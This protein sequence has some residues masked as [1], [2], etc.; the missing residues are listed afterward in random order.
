MSRH[1]DVK[2]LRR[3]KEIRERRR[4]AE[5]DDLARWHLRLAA[6]H[7]LEGRLQTAIEESEKALRCREDLATAHQGLAELLA[8]SNPRRALQHLRRFLELRPGTLANWY[9]RARLSFVLDEYSD[10]ESACDRLLSGEFGRLHRDDRKR[11]QEM[12]SLNEHLRTPPEFTP[13]TVATKRT[14]AAAVMQ[15]ERPPAPALAPAP[16]PA[17]AREVAITFEFEDLALR[18]AERLPPASAVDYH[19]RLEALDLR[20]FDH[21]AALLA[22][23]TA[24]GLTHF[25]HQIE[26]VKRVL[27]EF[28]GRA[29]LADEVGLGKTIEAC[30]ILK[31]YLLRGLVRRV[32]ILTPPS[33]VEQWR[34]ELHAKFSLEFV[35][36]EHARFR[37]DRERFLKEQRCVILSLD[38]ARSK[39]TRDLLAAEEYDLIIVDEAH[40]LRR[41]TSESWKL[42]DSLKSRML[43]MLTAT[44]IQNDLMELYNLITLLK[45]GHLKTAKQF[46][47]DYVESGD[48][49]SPR[50]RE[51]L[52]R[53]LGEVMI[54][55]TRAAVDVGLPPRRAET[56]RLDPGP[57]EIELYSSVSAFVRTCFEENRGLNRF[58][59]QLLQRECASSPNAVGRTL[60]KLAARE[61]LAEEVRRELASLSAR[62][63]VVTSVR[64]ID[65]LV[66]LVRSGRHKLVVF[67]HFHATLDAIERRL[68]AEAISCAVY[69]GDL[70]AAEKDAAIEKFRLESPLLLSSEAGGEGRNLQFADAICNFDLPWNPMRIEQRIGRVHRIG[71][72]QVVTIY[73]LAAAGTLEGHLLEILDRKLNLFELVIG[74]LDM[75]LG[76]LRDEREFEDLVLEAWAGSKDDGAA[77]ASLELLGEELQAAREKYQKTRELDR[78]LFGE[79]FES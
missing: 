68:A 21:F 35:T 20:L 69:R 13:A 64:K 41:R 22:L 24:Q 44:P 23:D 57:G 56:I 49:T 47:D 8:E 67:T 34:E 73:N 60:E 61:D 4:D 18:P 59:L 51:K 39:S 10:C 25:R 14:G 79:D 48:P 5:H 55:N 38:T 53:L 76:N 42:V 19:L 74:E 62:A 30:L 75:I 63:R 27:R 78:S 65:A 40:R 66:Q 58:T 50:Q 70:S 36:S 52:R 3:K 45:P 43:L 32:L 77:A 9:E 46:R 17:A 1:K 72:K 12:K 33:L 7:V 2:K 6:E 28:H 16:P 26:T 15:R 54:R 29:L 31:E 71:Q 11:L 37:A